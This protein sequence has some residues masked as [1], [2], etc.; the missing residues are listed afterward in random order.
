MVI[1]VPAPRPAQSEI[2]LRT[3]NISSSY[4][5]IECQD[6]KMSQIVLDETDD[7]DDVDNVFSYKSR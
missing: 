6:P 7:N 1:P 4:N 5:A 3:K 2:P